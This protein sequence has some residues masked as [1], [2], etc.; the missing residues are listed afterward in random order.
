MSLSSGTAGGKGVDSNA[1]D[2][3]DSGD[4]WD[5]GVGNLIIDLDA[6]LEKDQQK[7]EMSGAKEGGGIAAT[8]SAVAALPDNIKFVSPVPTPQSKESKS[9]SKRSKNSKDSGKSSVIEGA[10]RDPQTRPQVESGAANAPG[11]T[12]N[13]ASSKATDKSAKASR[14][15]PSGKK[16]KESNSGKNKKDKGEGASSMAEKDTGNQVVNLAAGPRSGQFEGVQSTDSSVADQLGSIAIDS[17][18]VTTPL[19]IKT[20]SEE[21]DNECRSLKKVKTEKMESPVSTPAPPPLHLLATVGNSDITSSCEQIMVRTRSVAVNTSD[22]ALATDP[23]CLGPCEPGTSVNLEGIVWQETED[24]M[25]V[26]NVT[27]RNK[28]YVGTLLDCT[29]HDW[30]PPRFCESPTSDLEMRNGRGRG[31]RIRPNSNTPVNENSNSSDNKGSSS[32]SKTRAGSNSKGRRGSQNSSERRTP[33]HSNTEDVKASPSSSNKRKSKPASD[34]EPNSS[35]EDTKGSK[36]MRTNSNSGAAPPPIALIPT[37]KTELLPSPLDRNCPSPILIDCPHPNCNKKYKH[38]NGLKYHQARAHNDDDIKEEMDG[39]SEYGEDSTLHPEPGNCNGASVSQKGCLSPARSTTPKGKAFEGPS[40]SPTGKFS[41]KQPSKKKCSEAEQE[42]GPNPIDMSEEGPCLSDETSNDGMDDKKGSDKDKSKKAGLSSAKNDKAPQKSLKSARPIAPAIPSQQLYTFQTATFTTG[43]SGSSPGMTTTVVQAMP[44]SP[45]L[46]AIQPKPTV[47]GDPSS[48]NPALNT[49]KEKKKKDKKK[50]EASK[51]ADSPKP[52]GK[53]GKAEE[54][55]SPYSESHSSDSG[56]KNDALLNG[57]SDPHQ[58]RLASMKAEAD[59]IYSFTDNAPSPSIGVASRMDNAGLVQPI[60]P[61][62]V[63]TQNGADNSSVKTNSPAYSDISDAGE[64]GEGKL[65]NVKAKADDQI[66]KE[67]AKKALFASQAPN[68]ESQYYTGYETY[69]SPNYVNP[70]PGASSS[71]TSLAESQPMKIKKEEEQESSELKVKGEPSEG[72]KLEIST[73]SQQHQ[74]QPSVIQ[75]RS[76]MYM[77][78]LYYNQYT[79]VPPY[80]Y[81]DHN[82][83]MSTNSAYRQQY[84]EHQRQRQ[85]SEQHRVT[86]KKTDT[87][88]KER[89]TVMREDWKQKS[90]VP[91]TLSKTSSLTDLSKSVSSG[92]PKDAPSEPSKS[93]IM[94]KMDDSSKIQSQQVEGLKMKLSEGSHHGKEMVDTK[95]SLECNRQPGMDHAMWYRQEPDARMWPYI[96]PNKYPESQKQQQQD[97]ERWKDDRERKGKDERARAKDPGPKDETK[98]SPDPRLALSSSE[99][100][101]SLSKDS[102]PTVHMQFSSPL[103]QHQSYMPYMHGYPYGQGYDPNHPGYRGMPSVMMQN[104]PGSYLASGYS[105]SPYGTKMSGSEEGEKSRASPTVSSKSSSEAKALD[106]LQQHASQY[107]SKSP[108]VSDKQMHERERGGSTGEREREMDRPRSSPSQ[109]LISSHHHL[110]YPLLSGQYDLPY[111]T[112]LSSSAIVASQQASA[113]SLYPPARR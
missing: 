100:H 37:L 29:R 1:V 19:G 70:S 45:Q 58:S 64:D 41:S 14:S 40:L 32:S 96:Y 90:S 88:M 106:I 12:N 59:K 101:R 56:I 78:P 111:A 34:M 69:Y 36:R 93:V 110:G 74:Q 7:L 73:S 15:V 23:E 2:T 27:W 52:F 109:R 113:P 3:Y 95:S 50:K 89:E 10:K 86:E 83:L 92:K 80:G 65:D 13:T 16:E 42:V 61:L 107:K 105:F 98:E 66:I 60:V 79:Y 38:I 55:K 39:D 112:G 8:P 75:Q 26:V 44:K 18:A 24:G 84:E 31:K 71:S 25:L 99:D 48:V 53:G 102:R 57:S 72:K 28:T 11:A 17:G 108:T 46:K 62:H 67:G 51:D 82:H 63:V 33:P 81:G 6:D 21:P 85:P 97:E 68:K 104:Y 54:G 94:T 103:A 20:E 30:A 77:H 35:S 76:N 5:I 22:V 91:P 4:E 47:M 87:V 49:S 43:N 9:K